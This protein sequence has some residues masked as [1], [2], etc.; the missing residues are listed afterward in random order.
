LATLFIAVKLDN[1]LEEKKLPKQTG[2][3]RE[4]MI[5]TSRGMQIPTP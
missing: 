3:K 4:E 5:I 2:K 1:V